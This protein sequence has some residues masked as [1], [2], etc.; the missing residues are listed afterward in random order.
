[1]VSHQ[2]FKQ[3]FEAAF[4]VNRRHLLWNSASRRTAY[5]MAYIYRTL[6]DSFP[7]L[8]SNMSSRTLTQF[9]TRAVLLIGLPMTMLS[10]L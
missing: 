6:A 9:Y 1:M 2:E 4:L 8:I 7:G 3:A 10:S 5:M